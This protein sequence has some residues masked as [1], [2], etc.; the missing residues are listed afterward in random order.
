MAPRDGY[1]ARIVLV[2]VLVF[3]AGC[4]G[5]F[6]GAQSEETLTPAP[7]PTTQPA[8]APGVTGDAEVDGS[9]LVAANDRILDNTSYRFDRTVRLAGSNSSL[10]INRTRQVR[11]NGTGIE[12][13][14]VKGTGLLTPAV[15]NWTV[16][17][18]GEIVWQRAILATGRTAL[19]RL[20]TDDEG[21]FTAGRELAVAVFTTG[22]FRIVTRTP[23]ETV[24]ESTEPFN[25]TDRA[26][27]DI[28]TP[29]RNATAR[30]VVTERG[31]I[32][33]L[34]L[35]YEGNLNGEPVTVRISQRVT[36][37]GETTASRPAWVPTT[38]G[39]V[40]TVVQPTA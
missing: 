17:N 13:L 38:N 5:L 14:S 9:R 26:V 37:L 31:V 33:N 30:A 29:A 28:A 6:G 4:V 27:P 7:V 25:L 34:T 21:P 36:G 22:E 1:L 16:W 35:I 15:Q 3:S 11:A 24:L 39:T 2:A 20:P 8:P 23:N 18:G 32:R 40:P 19:N 12:R 10:V